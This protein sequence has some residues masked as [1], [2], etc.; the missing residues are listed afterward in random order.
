MMLHTLSRSIPGLSKQKI[1]ACCYKLMHNIVVQVA[2]A[3][4]MNVLMQ[5]Y[6]EYELVRKA[7]LFLSTAT[8]FV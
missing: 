6:I 1:E 3:A 2:T 4:D 7:R 5:R 8:D